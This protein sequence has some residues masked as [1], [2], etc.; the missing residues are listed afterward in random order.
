MDAEIDRAPVGADHHDLAVVAADEH[1]G[2]ALRGVVDDRGAP[3]ESGAAGEAVRRL[4]PP[5]LPGHGGVQRLEAPHGDDPAGV[6]AH[7]PAAGAGDRVDR[8]LVRPD[9][10]ELRAGRAPELERAVLAARGHDGLTQAP[11]REERAVAGRRH[12][13][14]DRGRGRRVAR[15]ERAAIVGR[16]RDRRDGPGH[17]ADA[18]AAC[19]AQRH[20]RTRPGLVGPDRPQDERAVLVPREGGLSVRSDGEDR[21]RTARA[22]GH[23]RR[24]RRGAVQRRPHEAAIREAE[25]EVLGPR[26]PGDAPREGPEPE[27]SRGARAVGLPDLQGAVAMHR[28]RQRP[29][30]ADGDVEERPEPVL[31]GAGRPVPLEREQARRSVPAQAGHEDVTTCREPH[32]GRRQL[33]EGRRRLERGAPEPDRGVGSRGHDAAVVEEPRGQDRARV[34]VADGPC[35]VEAF[36]DVGVEHRETAARVADDDAP[37]RRRRERG[38]G[39][40]EVD[41][42]DRDRAQDA[43]L[44][45]LRLEHLHEPA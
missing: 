24:E 42:P 33:R 44:P 9:A 22:G 20:E 29:V 27:V 14:R 21:D 28:R 13:A 45:G 15:P 17:A 6:G 31:G 35:G 25:E 23:R 5:A 3:G 18:A 37:P 41:A 2:R 7:E 10:D 38:D 8:S 1:P 11:E 19:P 16:E 30:P 43:A 39:G 36:G 4:D 32:G 40:V 26:A 12:L 34:G